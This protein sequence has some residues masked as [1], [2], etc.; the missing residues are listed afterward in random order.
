MSGWFEAADIPIPFTFENG[1]LQIQ[2]KCYWYGLKCET[3]WTHLKIE[4][5]YQLVGRYAGEVADD[6]ES[7]FLIADMIAPT[8]RKHLNLLSHQKI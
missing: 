4:N 6:I 5:K 1:W 3:E 7:K 2:V 8:E